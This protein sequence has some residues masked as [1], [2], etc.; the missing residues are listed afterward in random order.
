MITGLVLVSHG[1]MSK[2]LL[3]SAELICGTQKNVAT[4]CLS[5]DDTPEAFRERLVLTIESLDAAAG[6]LVLIDLFGGTPSNV[7]AALTREFDL[8]CLT[9]MNLPMLLEILMSRDAGAS[10]SDLV[11]L[12][13]KSGKEGIINLSRLLE[14]DD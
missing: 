9:G 8:Q 10:A 11:E 3:E 14:G 12:G 2:H 7:T 5:P 4:V 6:S 13:E 1:D